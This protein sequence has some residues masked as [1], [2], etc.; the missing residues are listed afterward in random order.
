[1]E[2]LFIGLKWPE[3]LSDQAGALSA[4]IQQQSAQVE[5]FLQSLPIQAQPTSPQ[6]LPAVP[7][8]GLVLGLPYALESPAGAAAGNTLRPL[9]SQGGAWAATIVDEQVEAALDDAQ[10][11]H[12]FKISKELVCLPSEIQMDSVSSS[13][14]AV[15]HHKIIALDANLR[16]QV[17]GSGVKA[18]VIDCGLDR[19]HP[20]FSKLALQEASSYSYTRVNFKSQVIDY[21]EK[22]PAD[23]L[24]QQHYHGTAVAGALCGKDC[25]IAPGI[26]LSVM[27]AFG[28]YRKN[29]ASFSGREQEMVE[30]VAIQYFIMMAVL[31][32]NADIIQMS[33]G[34]PE[35]SSIFLE[36]LA[37]CEKRNC[38]FVAS[39][40]NDGPGKHH[41]PGDYKNV[42]TVGA[43][44][45]DGSGNLSAYRS[46]SSGEMIL[47]GE[48]YRKPDIWSPGKG[49]RVPVPQGVS[50]D[51]YR[52]LS[53]TSFSAPIVA[54]VAALLIG[55]LKAANKSYT[56][57]NIREHLLAT[58]S[59]FD[60]PQEYGGGKGRLVNAGKAVKEIQ[61]SVWGPP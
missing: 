52:V 3:Q 60:L 6:D 23:E 33:M 26:S 45:V 24:V 43:V 18:A 40:G 25:G 30:W 4:F 47:D 38:L 61:K 7:P 13:Q 41:S 32:A 35:Y 46:T 1:M 56:S 17:N 20:E 29:L 59:D 21:L 49:I 57:G 51:G 44:Q 42:L 12:G 27:N 15:D 34:T 2:K 9:S 5:D 58:A 55:H 50:Q 53:G 28:D 54:G 16:G 48:S 36:E 37:Q 31:D 14:S 11:E 8:G 19:S 10:E 39:A 22:R